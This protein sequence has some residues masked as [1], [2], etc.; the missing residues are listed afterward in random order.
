MRCVETLSLV[1]TVQCLSCGSTYS[2]P[3]A[4]GTFRT[5]PGCPNCGYL[6][7]SSD[8]P[9]TGEPERPRSAADLLRD[10]FGRPR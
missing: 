8:G 5:N 7:W 10:R 3:E 9:L 2:K 1:V 6:G 4:G